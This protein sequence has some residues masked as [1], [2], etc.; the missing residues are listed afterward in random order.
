M[1]RQ[2]LRERGEEIAKRLGLHPTPSPVPG[3]DGLMAEAVY[4]EIWGRPQL[5]LADRAICALAVLSALQ[6]LPALKSLVATA[7]GIGLTPRN[8]VEVF[9]Q[10]GLYAGFVTSQQSAAAA[11]EV[12][13]AR[14][15]SMA[16][17]PE[18]DDSMEMLDRK[19]REVMLELHGARAQEGYAAPGNAVT[20]ALYAMAIRY[21]YGE[22]WSR[23]GLTHR[24]RM[25]CALAAFTTM[26]LEDQLKKFA[27]SALNVGLSREEVIEAI[28]Q[29]AP[30]AGFPRA[31]NALAVA[32]EA[33][34]G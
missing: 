18:S 22:L 25:L 33:L 3:L 7:L 16:A 13:G 32:S 23:P 9:V 2:S 10:V 17:E 29:T 12:F 8:I 4:A 30:Y 31:L 19:G 27:K 34:A 5:P 6:R 26:G 28:I 21:G 24:Q 15:L 20:G 11:Q 14:G 1:S